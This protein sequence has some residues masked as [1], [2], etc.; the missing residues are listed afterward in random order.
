MISW[1]EIRDYDEQFN[2]DVM[3]RVYDIEADGR[4]WLLQNYTRLNFKTASHRAANVR[5]TSGL[6]DDIPV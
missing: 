2:Q 6:D 1:S 5:N 3:V 4:K